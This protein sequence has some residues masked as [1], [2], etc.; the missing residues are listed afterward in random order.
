M[1]YLCPFLLFVVVYRCVCLCQFLFVDEHGAPVE[2][3]G[4]PHRV[5]HTSERLLHSGEVLQT[6]RTTYTRPE[7]KISLLH[8]DR[9]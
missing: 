2:E 6:T 5:T 4:L 1:F 8:T 9:G 3:G 7:G